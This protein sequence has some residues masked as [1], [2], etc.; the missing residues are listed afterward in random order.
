VNQS[1]ILDRVPP[2]DAEVERQVIGAMI[3]DA[4]RIDEVA[5]IVRA[6][7]FYVDA[8]RILFETLLK[9]WDQDRTVNIVD[10]Q[11]HLKQGGNLEAVGGDSYL[12]QVFAT[13]AVAYHAA[14]HAAQ[15]AQYA[16]Y[17]RMILVG[18]DL[19]RGGYAASSPPTDLANR[20]ESEL[21]EIESGE[22]GGEPVPA[23]DCC[24]E[25]LEHI[26]HVLAT[27]HGGGVMIGLRSFDADY[28]GLF[29]GELTILAARIRIGKTA[30]ARQIA[31]N[32][33]KRGKLV[34]FVSAE[35]VRRDLTL[36]D[37][38]S[39]ADVS[40][41]MIR[42]GRIGADDRNRLVE[43]ANEFAG[44][45]V[46]TMYRP[47]MTMREITRSARRLLRDGL[48]LVIIDYLQRI[49]ASDEDRR[50]QR[51]VQVGNNASACKTLAG[52]LGV[53]VLC[54]CQTGR[55][56]EKNKGKQEG[57]ISRPS[58]ADLRE[59]G[60]I[61]AHAD[62][63]IFLHRQ[64]SGWAQGVDEKSTELL[65]AKY[66]NGPTGAYKLV[67]NGARMRLEDEDDEMF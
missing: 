54:L 6:K 7:D 49:R 23:D 29:P 9:M 42:T 61:E 59:S 4:R 50:A 13:V 45:N 32:V 66:R 57:K 22:Y 19:V 27:G 38:T 15:V 60:D 65:I 39:M 18:L 26:D 36:R 62:N 17:R 47:S 43:A 28:G 48:A 63:V 20:A 35:M 1:E 51:Y 37:L 44:C 67:W 25:A 46:R 10:L 64:V 31:R 24:R 2:H 12:F 14:H 41:K 58:L 40:L 52:E 5:A 11:T 30:F 53:P 34:L 21:S 55:D 8:H 16:A 3:L 56:V 33:G